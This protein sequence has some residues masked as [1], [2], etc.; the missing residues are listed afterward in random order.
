MKPLFTAAIVFIVG[1]ILFYTF[2]ISQA[3]EEI[4]D[5]RV[6]E[7]AYTYETLDYASGIVQRTSPTQIVLREYDYETD[8]DK[9]VTYMLD[10]KV[11]FENVDSHNNITIGDI[12]DIEYITRGG[13]RVATYIYVEKRAQ[14]GEG[15]EGYLL[16][17]E[18]WIGEEEMPLEPLE[19]LPEES[20]ESEAYPPEFEEAEY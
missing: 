12:A 3:Q 17:G 13:R 10:T 7:A 9:E 2:D 8:A 16:E 20:P 19:E 18:E 6:P 14:E 11:E 15:Q 4:L 1:S 5:E